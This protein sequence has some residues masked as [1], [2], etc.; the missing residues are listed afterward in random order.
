[1]VDRILNFP[2][3]KMSK[4]PTT[5]IHKNIRPV[6]YLHLQIKLITDSLGIL[7]LKDKHFIPSWFLNFSFL[8]PYIDFFNM[9]I[10]QT[11]FLKINFSCTNSSVWV[12]SVFI[13]VFQ[14][15][16]PGAG[17]CPLWLMI[18]QAVWLKF[19]RICSSKKEILDI[20][21]TPNIFRKFRG[22]PIRHSFTNFNSP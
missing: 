7:S 10:V 21:W 13:K 14:W 8:N 19:E 22:C 3:R 1:M 17:W 9:F 4:A 11:W 6:T 15:L 16:N 18:L 5:Y 2:T 20:R 12:W